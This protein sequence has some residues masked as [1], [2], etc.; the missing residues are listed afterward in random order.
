MTHVHLLDSLPFITVVSERLASVEPDSEK[1][2]FLEVAGIKRPLSDVAVVDSIAAV[3]TRELFSE[4]VNKDES[5]IGCADCRKKFL[6]ILVVHE[7]ELSLRIMDLLQKKGIASSCEHIG[8]NNE[9]KNI[10]L[11]FRKTA[12]LATQRVTFIPPVYF[13]PFEGL[14]EVQQ[15]QFAI[16]SAQ[17]EK[18][19]LATWHLAG[20]VAVVGFDRESKVGFL[21]HIDE[22][23]DISGAI[24]Q[25]I[26]TLKNDQSYIF[27]YRLAGGADSNRLEQIEDHFQCQK[28]AS[29][30]FIK[31]E[32]V[33]G[34]D[35][36]FNAFLIDSYWSRAVRLSRSIAIDLRQEDPLSQLMGYEAEIN[37]FSAIHKR[38]KTIEEADQFCHE[39]GSEMKMVSL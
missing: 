12:S 25:F 34:V 10:E 19:V 31:R 15:R 14:C 36:P 35:I 30:S 4:V 13:G 23:S 22:G 8:F 21:F 39:T 6:H 38:A 7:Y 33:K 24:Q 37:P 32:Y 17:A 2:R 9:T 27:E 28:R 26:E 1:K 18:P 16:S 5:I 29:V 11:F 3:A 20:C